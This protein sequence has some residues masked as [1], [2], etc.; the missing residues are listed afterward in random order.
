MQN[1]LNQNKSP[2]THY[3]II[4]LGLWLIACTFSF[5]QHSLPM[6]VSDIVCG[7]LLIAI[8][9][10]DLTFRQIWPRWTLSVVA[11][12]LQFAPLAFW[13]PE[14][15]TYLNDTLVGAL[16]IALAVLIPK[17]P[18]EE[19]VSGASIPKG[20]SYNPSSWPQRIPIIFL[21]F[22]A[23]MFAR[24]MACYQLGYLDN[25]YDPVFGN[26]TRDV[27][28]STVSKEFPV[29]DAGLGAMAYT[30]ETLMGA[31]GGV[32]RWHTIPWFVVLFAILVVPLG[33]TSIVLIMLQPIMV[34]HWCFWCLLTAVCMLFMIALALDEVIAV[35]HFLHQSK[36][37]GNF[38]KVFWRGGHAEGEETD[39]RTPSVASYKMAGSMIWGISFPWNLW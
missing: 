18:I 6:A 34:G 14:A 10:Y 7:I 35:L 33:F 21:G 25:V 37:K 4:G 38:S 11:V 12:W 15:V 20:W 30:I 17:D 39:S 28:T 9:L 24:Y 32:K 27:I 19:A 2:W 31:H 1:N 13:A 26:G 36:K 23:W 16:V 29:A 8:S 22:F 5:T 3:A